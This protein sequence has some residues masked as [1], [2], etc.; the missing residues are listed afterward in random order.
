MKIVFMGTPD[1]AVPCLTAL[2]E[3][4][5][6]V[7]A[8]FTQPDKPKGRGYALTPPPVKVKALEYGLPVYQPTTLRDGEA[9]RLL[10]EIGPDVIAVVAYGKLLPGEILELPPMGCVNVHASLLPRHRGAS[11]IQWAIVSG[12]RETGVTTMYMAEGMDTGD[13]LEKTVTPIG[14]D[15][16]AAELHDRLSNLGAALLVHTLNGMESGEIVPEKQD[17]ALATKAPIIRKEMGRLDFSKSAAELHNLARGFYPWPGVYT[18]LDGKRLKVLET[19]LGEGTGRPGEVIEADGR[20]LVAC[21]DG[22][23]LELKK[24]QPEGKRPMTAAEWLRGRPL[25][26]GTILG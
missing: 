7:A 18:Q 22:R 21:G 12:D 13:I 24:V 19:G 23:A 15:E 3:A 17:D 6:E 9:L 10:K 4:G 2:R 20:L 11:P 14:P 16:T 5:H 25:N 26:R 8:V 1:F